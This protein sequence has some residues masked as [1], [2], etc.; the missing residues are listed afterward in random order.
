MKLPPPGHIPLRVTNVEFNF[1][2]SVVACSSSQYI[3]NLTSH[4]RAMI[5]THSFDFDV[6]Y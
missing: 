5:R 2:V 6:R 4:L 1:D 3:E